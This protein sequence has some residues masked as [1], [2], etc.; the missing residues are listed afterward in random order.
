MKFSISWL[1]TYLQ[2]SENIDVVLDCLNDLGLEVESVEDPT[3]IYRNFIVGRIDKVEKHPNADKLKVCKVFLGKDTKDIVCGANNV[4]TGMG[5]V[6]ALPGTYIPGLGKKISIGKI[7]GVESHGMMCSELELNLSDEHDGIISLKNPKVGANFSEWLSSNDPDKIDPVIEIG[8]TPNRPD[9][10]GVYGIAR[11]LYAKGLGKLIPRKIGDIYST[12]DSPV[13]VVLDNSVSTKDCPYFLGRYIKGINNSSSPDWL[14]NRLIKIGLRPISG[15]VDLTNFLTFDSARPLHAFD[16]DRL[17]GDLVVRK[18]KNGEELKAL[19]GNVYKLD[20]TMTVIA[21]SKCVQAIGGII[22]G[23]NSGCSESTKNIFIESAY[24]DPIS[25]AKT[26][27]KLGL[28][29]D[30]RYRFERGIDPSFTK[31][32]LEYYTKLALDL[33]GGEPSN[34]VISGKNPHIPKKFKMDHAKVEK[35]TGIK[36]KIDKQIDILSKLGFTV[37]NKNRSLTV[38]VP[39]WR[40]DVSG[41]I[42]LVEEVIRVTSLNKLNSTPLP[43][44]DFGVSVNKI[45]KRQRNISKIRRFL[46]SNGLKE[47]INYSFIDKESAEI[48]CDDK[49]LVML[50]NSISKEMTNLRPSLIPGLLDVVKKNQARGLNDIAIFEIGQIFYGSEPGEET[51]E[52]SG[53]FTGYSNDRNAFQDR[54]SYDIYDAKFCIEESLKTVGINLDSLFLDREVP[55]YFHP[56]KSAFIKL[57]KFKKLAIF[58][59]L[60]PIISNKYGL[61]NH[62]VIFSIFLEKV[63]ENK[64]KSKN[65]KFIN[66]PY[67]SV[68]RDFAF[69]V[70]KKTEAN[71]I[72]KII[73]NINRELI[74][75]IKLFDVFD[76]QKAHDQIGANKKSLA[77]EVTIQSNERT[78]KEIEIED[79]SHKI[80]SNVIEQTGGK[81][82]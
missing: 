37:E 56:N 26:G 39:S 46:A 18:A 69:V 40:P 12:F 58:G 22:G 35:I 30:A 10:L 73:K 3:N 42:D 1:K 81:L 63:T 31:A 68:I 5:V 19:D 24:F 50:S 66:S 25:T 38:H 34:L 16:A 23:E 53:V 79:L 20:D 6:V 51:L 11:D 77:F 8:I 54:R 4:E 45:N 74:T 21:D 52:L 71:E 17:E 9:A 44:N 65:V 29:T 13:D 32:G 49:D 70:D 2:Y 55:S 64:N 27:R 60:N 15:L 78:L 61:K 72:I 62:P 57:G 7:R 75:G 76:G 82:R 43:R 14:Q 80:I 33:F 36:I 47:T 28:I 59:E 48:F 67:P 41:E